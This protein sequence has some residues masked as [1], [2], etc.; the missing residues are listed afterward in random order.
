MKRPPS[1]APEEAGAGGPAEETPMATDLGQQPQTAPPPKYEQ[2]FEQELA[3][4][5]GRIRRLDTVG[6]VLLLLIGVVSYALVMAVLDR[7]FD[8]PAALR[9]VAFV[10]FLAAAGFY[11]GVIVFRLVSWQV[12][13]YYAARRLEETLP[14]AKNSLINWLDLRGAAMPPVIRTTLGRKAAKDLTAAD[15]ENAVSARRA[16]WLAGVLVG[17]FLV[18]LV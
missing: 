1:L 18:L 17:L 16:L 3:K 15:L 4:A 6:A 5:R 11:L 8:L 13:P 10:A 2:V 9:G 7:A 14:D 12:N